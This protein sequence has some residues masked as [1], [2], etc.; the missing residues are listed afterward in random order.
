MSRPTDAS[1]CSR[2]HNRAQV[3]QECKQ[4]ARPPSELGGQHVRQQTQVSPAM[5]CIEQRSLTRVG[6]SMQAL[7]PLGQL[8]QLGLS[9]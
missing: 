1:I 7:L 2:V 6:S 5:P 4:C 8:L 3:L 9:R